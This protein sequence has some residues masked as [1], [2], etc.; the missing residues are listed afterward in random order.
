MRIVVDTLGRSEDVL[1]TFTEASDFSI[2]TTPREVRLWPWRH[3]A[4]NVVDCGMA[5]LLVLFV[6]S[7]SLLLDF[8]PAKAPAQ[9]GRG[10][11]G[12]R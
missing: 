10:P 2:S 4:G 9:G 3:W 5:T 12:K 6:G 8:D 7:S 11:L 1:H